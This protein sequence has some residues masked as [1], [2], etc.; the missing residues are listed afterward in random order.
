MQG[1]CA[2][3]WSL[4]LTVAAF[5]QQSSSLKCTGEVVD[6][7]GRSVD[8]VKVNAYEIVRGYVDTITLRSMGERITSSN[9]TFTFEVVPGSIGRHLGA[10]LVVAKENCAIGWTNWDMEKDAHVSIGLGEPTQLEGRIC[11]EMGAPIEG[12]E[13]RAVLFRKTMSGG[14]RDWLPGIAPL[15]WLTVKSNGMGQFRFTNIPSD[16]DVDLLVSAPGR[17]LIYTHRPA[18]KPR[19]TAGQT[20]VRIVLSPEARIEG[21]V[22][23]AETGKGIPKVALAVESSSSTT[24]FDRFLCIT[25]ED[26]TFRLGGLRA[27]SYR[28]MLDNHGLDVWIV[29]GETTDD[30]LIECPGDV[31]QGRVTGPDGEPV[32]NAK[33]QIREYNP[34]ARSIAAPNTQTDERG[35]YQY[36]GIDWPYSIGCLWEQPLPNGAGHRSLYLRD[37]EVRKDSQTVNFEFGAFPSGTAGFSGRVTDQHGWALQDFRVSITNKV[38]WEDRSRDIQ[39]Y[40]Y[41]FSVNTT[42]GRFAVSDLP[43][44]VYRVGIYDERGRVKPYFRQVL[45]EEGKIWNVEPQVTIVSTGGKAEKG[46]PYHG[47]VLFDDG[48]PAVAYFPPWPG[49]RTVVRWGRSL[50][51]AYSAEVDCE[52]YFAAYLKGESLTALYSGKDHIRINFPSHKERGRS[53]VA[54]T[55]PVQLLSMDKCKAGVVKIAKPFDSKADWRNALPLA[56]GALPRLGDFGIDFS[57]IDMNDKKILICFWDMEQRPSRHCIRQLIEQ[58]DLLEQKGVII[59][60]VQTSKIDRTVL[61]EWVKKYNVPFL[62]GMIQG[63]VEEIRLTWGVKSLP[64]LILTDRKHIVRVEGFDITE[65]D[66]RIQRI[67]EEQ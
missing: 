34:G 46:I 65:L 51:S 66:A 16:V 33:I 36:R 49:A 52:G 5:S 35:F 9:G 24:F 41:D 38:D 45:L 4:F 62:V 43:A 19:F 17:A 21:R 48:T 55:F 50:S 10:I 30:I 37:H 6:A 57:Q 67:N 60:A 13:I 63:D 32:V 40:I 64:W 47:R 31:V 12:A 14:A 42:D 61:N 23:E 58:A 20:D 15:P 26:G 29:S 8:E 11:N 59:V 28:V 1:K 25:E 22:V 2:L 53:S 44:G 3:V 56:G 27:G 39:Q 18:A 54:G 7:Q